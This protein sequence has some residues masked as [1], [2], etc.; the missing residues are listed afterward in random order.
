MPE[1]KKPVLVWIH[2]GGYPVGHSYET[3]PGHRLAKRGDVVVVSVNYRL[4]ALGFMGHPELTKEGLGSSGTYG[5]LD[6][7]HALKWIRNNIK[8][9][10]GDEYNV[11][12]MGESAGGMS[13]CNLLASPLSKKVFHFLSDLSTK[14]HIYSLT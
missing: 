12:I 13:V 8:F 5:M 9:F 1:K 11:T 7:L 4:G 14:K 2:G 10:G 3:T 6:Q